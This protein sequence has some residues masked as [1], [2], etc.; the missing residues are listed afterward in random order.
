MG[1]TRLTLWFIGNNLKV[2][3]VWEDVPP[4][5]G[6]AVSRGRVE[7]DDRCLLTHVF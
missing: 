5:F 7:V 1:R 6:A 3:G 4:V 2:R